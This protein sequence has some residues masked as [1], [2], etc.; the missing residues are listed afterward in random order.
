MT[1]SDKLHRN[2]PLIPGVEMN[3]RLVRNKISCVSQ[4]LKIERIPR[5]AIENPHSRMS[6]CASEP[7]VMSVMSEHLL[8]TAAKIRVSKWQCDR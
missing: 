1:L 3:I 2:E 5:V 4:T 8:S 6:R 7:D